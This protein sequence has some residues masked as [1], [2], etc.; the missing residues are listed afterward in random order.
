MMR[1]NTN[2]KEVY[3]MAYEAGK[4]DVLS[5]ARLHKYMLYG[6]I[7]EAVNNMRDNNEF[8]K[9]MYDKVMKMINIVFADVE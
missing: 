3:D 1:H 8:G 9:D 2:L 5:E 4:Q 6:D 7:C